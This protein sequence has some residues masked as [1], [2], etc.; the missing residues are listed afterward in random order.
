[1]IRANAK[2]PQITESELTINAFT[3]L[4]TF[5][6]HA[7]LDSDELRDLLNCDIFSPSSNFSTQAQGR[8]YLKTRRGSQV[9]ISQIC[10]DLDILNHVTF[11]SGDKEYAIIQQLVPTVGQFT[12]FSEFRFIELDSTGTFNPVVQKDDLSNFTL[13]STEKVDMMVSNQK[14]YIFNN[15][16]NSILEYNSDEE[17]FERRKMG[18]PAPM[19]VEI[20]ASA[21]GVPGEGLNGK[22]VYGVELVYKNTSVTPNVDIIVSGPNRAIEVTATPQFKE[23]R[24]SYAEGT[25]K[26][27]TAT[28]SAT[29]NDG[30]S[31][32]D[33]ENS[34]WTHIRLYRSKDVTT[35]TNA[36]PDLQGPAEIVGRED[37]LFQ[38]GEMDK[39]AFLL[40]L[41]GGEYFFTTDT[42][43]DDNIPFP[44]DV[45]TGEHLDMSVIPAAEIGTFHRNRIWVSGVL[46]VPGPSGAYALESISSKIFYTP[47]SS[48][49]YSESSRAL[50]AIESDPGD[51]QKMVKLISLQEDL[52]GIKEGKTGRVPYGDP[53]SGWITEDQVIG[54]SDK[55]FA[56]FV[57]NVGICAIV[58]DQGDFRIFGYNLTWVSVFQGLQISRPIRNIVAT[59]TPEDINF[60]YMNGKLLISSG[61]GLI[62]VLAVEQKK[63]W[64]IYQ[65]PLNG[66]SEAAFTFNEGRRAA[67]INRNQNVVEIEVDNLDTD[68]SASTDSSIPIDYSLIT[69]KFQD[70]IGRSLIE[71]RW[72][73]IVAALQTNI[74][75]QPF[76]NG[77]LWDIPFN[78]LLDPVDY[79][80]IALRETEYQGYSEIKPIANY[81]HYVISGQ[82]PATIY[83]IQLNCLIQRG[84][85]QAGFDPFQVLQMAK[86]AP[87][88]ADTGLIIKDAADTDRIIGD[89]TQNDAGDTSR[90]IGNFTQ[91]DAGDED[92]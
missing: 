22:R 69:Y 6:P 87:D 23:G 65:Y 92:R 67:I 90:I 53:A 5:G 81:I 35:A 3:G 24:L 86:T 63:G 77:K 17:R 68:Y 84:Q 89:F 18:L 71:Q 85:L 42:I 27:Y 78:M 16:G 34:N 20:V 39:A 73:S 45:V 7:D 83:S 32:T 72:L 74:S 44:L 58:N 46:V 31:I 57:P 21:P 38:V 2:I 29:L 12:G 82:A 48:T 61:T 79:P 55:G 47:E 91:D 80:E 4:N 8:G 14:V 62:L 36:T 41:S 13:A 49:K 88:W 54:I 76:V 9:L 19:I 51:G 40:T 15:A 64:G 10:P 56:Q 25:D 66:L 60:L 28:I 59:F 43:L 11:D 50:D 37:E 75:C 70:S 30:S 33:S 52:I 26:V 1:M